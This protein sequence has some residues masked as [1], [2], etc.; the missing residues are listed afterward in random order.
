METRSNELRFRPAALCSLAFSILM[1]LGLAAG[2]L[3]GAVGDIGDSKVI[4]VSMDGWSPGEPLEINNLAGKMELSG[5]GEPSLRV[6]IHAE[7]S[8]GLSVSEILELVDV[9]A[10]K[11]A[12]GFAVTTVL[13]L[14]RFTTYAYPGNAVGGDGGGGGFFASWFD[15]SSSSNG[16]FDGKKVKVITKSG[17]GS[18]TV[19]ADYLLVVPSGREVTMNNFVG[20]LKVHDADGTFSLDTASGDVTASDVRGAL[21]VDTGSGDVG[22]SGFSGTRL[23]I[24][25]G[26]G[27]ISVAEV[28][29]D[30]LVADTGSGD[31]DV[32]CDLVNC[33]RMV[34]DTGSGDVVISLPAA[35]PFS[36]RA[37]TGSGDVSGNLDGAHAV[38]DDDELVGFD[39]GT[40]GTTILVDTGS[41]DVTVRNR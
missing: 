7:A 25:T 1:V 41:G 20:V 27:D 33:R 37:D 28:A 5:G 16:T 13:P 12:N 18:L 39:R 26:S 19:W 14:D 23:T 11:V 17:S 40:G 29:A 38:M 9:R 15:G 2:P 10:K 34:V 22:V 30:K 32:D 21:L 36:L 31:V 3:F 24:D 35:A 6:T 8:G 4:Q